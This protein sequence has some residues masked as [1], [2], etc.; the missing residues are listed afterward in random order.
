MSPS[1]FLQKDRWAGRLAC[2]R[3]IN[4]RKLEADR[5]RGV[6]RGEEEK[7]R[8]DLGECLWVGWTTA[9]LGLGGSCARRN[10]TETDEFW[11]QVGV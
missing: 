3:R 9:G 10:M 6:G 2:S 1:D 5:F 4:R 7:Q 8:M 11:S